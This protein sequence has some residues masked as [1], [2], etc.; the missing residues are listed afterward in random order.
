MSVYQVGG[1]V[2][3]RLMGHP[4]RDIDYVVVGST[5]QDMLKAGFIQVGADFPVFLHPE[6]HAEYALARTERK[7]GSGYHGFAVNIQNVTLEE[8]LS[9]RDL[10]INAMAVDAQGNLIDPFS[11]QTDLH[12]K[13]FRH[14]SH[15]FAEDPLRVLRVL[16]FRARYGAEWSYAP[17]TWALMQQMV[18]DNQL[19]EL[20]QERVFKELQKGLMEPHPELL[21]EGMARLG[22]HGKKGFESYAQLPMRNDSALAKACEQ[23]ACLEVRFVLAFGMEILAADKFVQQ[24]PKSV[25]VLQ[26]RYKR[27][28]RTGKLFTSKLSGTALQY[29][30]EVSGARKQGE[31]FSQLISLLTALGSPLA[32]ILPQA[33]KALD[34]VDNRVVVSSRPQGV[35]PAQ[36]IKKA[37]VE[38]L[39]CVT[40]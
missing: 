26:D 40:A 31:G 17:E 21:L 37:Q 27:L 18:D 11:G 1:C 2:R 25:Q 24:V 33:S 29:L 3:D 35:S 9:R 14:V 12:H 16:R 10:T 8:D 6:T 34:S 32:V 13:V 30:T 15:A 20:S 5:P 36:A 23:G 22:L 28:A 7:V 19:S 39:S 4:V 38:A